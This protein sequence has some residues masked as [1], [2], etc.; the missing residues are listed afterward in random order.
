MAAVY[1]GGI[2]GGG[3]HSV[4]KVLDGDGRVL[5]SSS[6]PGTNLY[7]EGMDAT[8]ERFARLVREALA[9]AGLPADTR[10]RA[11]GISSSGCEVEETNNQLRDQL[12]ARH[13]GLAERCVV[14]SDSVGAVVTAF[15]RGG[16]CLISGTGSNSLLLNPDGGVHRCGGWS[17]MLGDEASAWWI[18]CRAVKWV[19][20]ED[21]NLRTP[22]HSTV[23][24]RRCI[25]Q[26]FN[27]TDRF[28]M[29]EHAY[30][31]FSKPKFAGLCQH[32]ARR[33]A[34][35][36]AFCR[37]L[38]VEAG[39]WLGR[40]VVAL[41]P[42]VSEELLRAP[43]GLSIVAVGAVF[44]SWDLMQVGFVQQVAAHLPAFTLLQLTGSLALGAAYMAAQEADFPL[45]KEYADN[46]HVLCTWRKSSPGW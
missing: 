4:A 45:P 21:D 46:S 42:N 8:I 10:L 25:K 31:S 27:I 36:D 16:I 32:L 12:L 13:P 33:R 38:F 24:A 19:F 30:T 1:F 5:A 23:V 6:G 3:G 34:R 11:L 35:G 15:A 9:A 28:G 26:Y 40:F 29:L 44:R 14:C 2:E 22:P 7:L 17:Y 37:E 41:L 39:R 20:D 43:G 18:A